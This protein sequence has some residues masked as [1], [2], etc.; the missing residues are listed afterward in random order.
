MARSSTWEPLI[1]TPHGLSGFDERFLPQRDGQGRVRWH[2]RG[3]WHQRD[4]EEPGDAAAL[5]SGHP[6]LSLLR[7]DFNPASPQ[8]SEALLRRLQRVER[9]VADGL[10][11]QQA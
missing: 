9:Q 3:N 8:G 6:T 7:P 1:I 11:E 4:G 10:E 5:R 2:L